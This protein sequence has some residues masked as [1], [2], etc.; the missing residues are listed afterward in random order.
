MVVNG[1]VTSEPMASAPAIAETTW[2]NR[3]SRKPRRSLGNKASSPWSGGDAGLAVRGSG[4]WVVGRR[5]RRSRGEVV[6]FGSPAVVSVVAGVDPWLCV[7]AFRRVCRYRRMVSARPPRIVLAAA[8]GCRRGAC[9]SLAASLG[10]HKSDLGHFTVTL[11]YY[12]PVGDPADAQR[13]A[14]RR[15]EPPRSL[16]CA[17]PRHRLQHPAGA[18]TDRRGLQQRRGQQVHRGHGESAYAFANRRRLAALQPAEQPV[19]GLSRAVQDRL[20]HP[21][22]A[23]LETE[24]RQVN[25]T[26]AN[27]GQGVGEAPRREVEQVPRHVEVE[28]ARFPDPRLPARAV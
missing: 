28:P 14:W 13:R 11:L 27:L 16:G 24:R 15:C 8:W 1:W 10:K 22:E 5:Q 17:L 2:L 6:H 25:R 21:V 7:P 23:R 20:E 19:R 12:R 3:R 18:G 4:W 26:E 9:A